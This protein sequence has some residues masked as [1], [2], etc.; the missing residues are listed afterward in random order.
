MHT[1]NKHFKHE[2]KEQLI[3][4]LFIITKQSGEKFNLPLKIKN[5]KKI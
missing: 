4:Q 3:N 2:V 5:S 1:V